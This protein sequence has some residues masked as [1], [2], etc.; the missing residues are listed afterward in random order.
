[1][2]FMESSDINNHFL[3][4]MPALQDPNFQRAVIYIC[5]HNAEGTVGIIVNRPTNMVLDQIFEQMQLSC[6]LEAVKSVPVFI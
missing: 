5:E 2:G 6:D 3:L 4:A 1:M